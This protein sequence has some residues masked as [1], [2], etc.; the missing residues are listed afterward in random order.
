[1]ENILQI[2]AACMLGYVLL[3]SITV[4]AVLVVFVL[5]SKRNVAVDT[6]DK[7]PAPKGGD[8]TENDEVRDLTY[9]YEEVLRQNN[10]VMEILIEELREVKLTLNENVVPVFEN[11]AMIEEL[12]LKLKEEIKNNAKLIARINDL[13][14]EK[15]APSA[16]SD[17]AES[18]KIKEL[19]ELIVHKDSYYEEISDREEKLRTGVCNAIKSLTRTR[20]SNSIEFLTEQIEDVIEVLADARGQRY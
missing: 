16:Q 12:E 14:A 5:K 13:E 7:E 10:K 19:E 18:K 11:C 9:M 17:D 20:G 8:A 6:D 2:L 3:L 1:M 15:V 4:T